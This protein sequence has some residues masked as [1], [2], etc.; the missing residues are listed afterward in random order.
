MVARDHLLE[1]A[2]LAALLVV[3][4][5]PSVLFAIT[6]AITVGRREALFTV[7]GNAVGVYLQVAAVAFGLGT[8]VAASA[9]VFTAVKV[10]GATYLIY[11]GLQA[12]RHRARPADTFTAEVTAL[13][14]GPL[15]ML[16]DGLIVGFANPKSL[17][18][19]AALLPQ[20][21]TPENGWVP[22]QM[23]ILG[24]CIP[25]FGLIFDSAWALTA[26]TA[27]AW[28]ARSP[29]RLAAVGGAGG[30]MM[31]G[32]GTSLALTGRKD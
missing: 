4:P 6:R 17:V 14:R 5:G 26:G 10:L 25:M 9:T 2:G 11:L 7:A 12:I 27:R 20:F 23:L 13:R 31:I 24:M 19:L 30:L 3:I 18:F 15:T 16:R 21:V 29:R 32:L 8:V 22:V 1:F 28:F